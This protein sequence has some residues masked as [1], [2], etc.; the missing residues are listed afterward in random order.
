MSDE[1]QKASTE[2]IYNQILDQ[3][4]VMNISDVKDF[5]MSSFIPKAAI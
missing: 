3:G 4:A 5:D 2:V 1:E